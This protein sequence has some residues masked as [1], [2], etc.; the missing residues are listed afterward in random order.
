ML[1]AIQSEN[2][3]NKTTKQQH[4]KTTKQQNTRSEQIEL[5]FNHKVEF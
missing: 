1:S 4:A 3:T 5:I 2:H